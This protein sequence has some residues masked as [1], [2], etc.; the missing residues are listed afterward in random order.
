MVTMDQEG[1]YLGQRPN[2]SRLFDLFS[3]LCP[4]QTMRHHPILWAEK[5]TKTS[6]AKVKDYII[7]MELTEYPWLHCQ[8][9]GPLHNNI[10]GA[11]IF[12]NNV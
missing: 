3:V 5:K 2:Y 4:C 8:G 12:K 11:P 7:T 10:R 9:V 1:L 6:I